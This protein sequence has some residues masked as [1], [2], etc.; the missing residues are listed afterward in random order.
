MAIGPTEPIFLS[1]QNRVTLGTAICVLKT[2]WSLF[3]NNADEKLS[4]LE[5]QVSSHTYTKAFSKANCHRT[6]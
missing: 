6:L 2:Y 1:V 4:L 3:R 5:T